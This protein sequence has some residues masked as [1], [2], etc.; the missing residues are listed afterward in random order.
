MWVHIRDSKICLQHVQL[1]GDICACK[2]W[3][4][5]RECWTIR[6]FIFAVLHTK[7]TNHLLSP[8]ISLSPREKVWM[9]AVQSTTHTETGLRNVLSVLPVWPRL[10]LCTT[11]HVQIIIQRLSKHLFTLEWT[12]LISAF[13]KVQLLNTFCFV[14]LQQWEEEKGIVVVV[15][16]C[17]LA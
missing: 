2:V 4:P 8:Y 11:S 9:S 1:K 12:G 6:S 3:E 5:T 16:L 15:H 17:H 13:L 10:H 7:K 14:T